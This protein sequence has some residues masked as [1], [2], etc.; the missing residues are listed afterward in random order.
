MFAGPIRGR[1]PGN[2]TIIQNLVTGFTKCN[3]T[4]SWVM[5]A[6]DASAGSLA[7]IYDGPL[8]DGYNPL[9]QEGGLSL[10][11]GGDG[12]NSSSGAFFE[13]V[14]IAA[15]TSNTTDSLIQANIASV[16][17]TNRSGSFSPAMD[18]SLKAWWDGNDTSTMVLGGVTSAGSKP[19]QTWTDKSSH[20]YTATQATAANRPTYFAHMLNGKGGLR[21]TRANN[22]IFTSTDNDNLFSTGF[23]IYYVVQP[24]SAPSSS[25]SVLAQSTSTSGAPG[26]GFS[27]ADTN[28]PAL[29]ISDFGSSA[30]GSASLKNTSRVPCI[31]GFISSQGVPATGGSLKAT[32]Y[33]NG[34]AGSVLT[35]NI[36]A[37]TATGLTIGSTRFNSPFDGYLYEIVVSSDT[38]AVTRQKY[39]G[40]F[41]A[42]YGLLGF[43]PAGHPYRD[44]A[45]LLINSMEPNTRAPDD[46]RLLSA[47][48]TGP[49]LVLSVT[50]ERICKAELFDAR[51]V[52]IAMTT[53]S[54]ILSLGLEGP[55]GPG[56]FILKLTWRT[57][58]LSSRILIL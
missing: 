57:C 43:L 16:Y 37:Y 14:V 46:F 25:Q 32:P 26:L 11:E 15:V 6:G 5:K 28:A 17:G 13:G 52:R 47:H 21:F 45:A 55:R 8:P 41:A 51:G 49:G 31:D 36:R 39:E 18:P 53:G 23:A 22:N 1:N 35:Q 12:S 29:A 2:P 48:Q 42:K 20:G 58:T 33:L 30:T 34:T 44:P 7:A 54:K 24:L 19:V 10:G 4:T 38:T 50:G 9:H 40:Y 3:G 56:F 27:V